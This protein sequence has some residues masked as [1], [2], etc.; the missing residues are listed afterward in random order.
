MYVTKSFHYEGIVNNK[1]RRTRNVAFTPK[2]LLQL[3]LSE[4]SN[5]RDKEYIN[6]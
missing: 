2:N 4:E 5:G 3:E 6:T 1:F